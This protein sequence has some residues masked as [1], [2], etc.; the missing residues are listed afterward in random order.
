MSSPAGF[1]R[2]REVLHKRAPFVV[3][4]VFD[5]FSLQVLKVFV[6]NCCSLV[7]KQRLAVADHAPQ[8]GSLLRQHCPIHPTNDLPTVG[9]LGLNGSVSGPPEVLGRVQF[10]IVR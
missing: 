2:L 6:E 4:I 1:D 7:K 10:S 5:D 9:L 3:L 8:D